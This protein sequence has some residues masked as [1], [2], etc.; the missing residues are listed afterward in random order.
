M[1]LDL[2][3]KRVLFMRAFDTDLVFVCANIRAESG[4]T[5]DL[6]VVVRDLDEF[7]DMAAALKVDYEGLPGLPETPG[8]C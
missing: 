8:R 3:S 6:K 2:V 7:G 4:I 1:A 5:L